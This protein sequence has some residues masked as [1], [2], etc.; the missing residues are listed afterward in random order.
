ME[1]LEK[2]MLFLQC[3]SRR[4]HERDNSEDHRHRQDIA[5]QNGEEGALCA[6]FPHG[7]AQEDYPSGPGERVHLGEPPSHWR[8]MA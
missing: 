5:K 7:M 6:A 3:I 2:D 1:L 8:R 4:K